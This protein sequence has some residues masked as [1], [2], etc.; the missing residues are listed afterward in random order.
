MTTTEKLNYVESIMIYADIMHAIKNSVELYMCLP[1]PR[2]RRGAAD[3]I[4]L[5]LSALNK[6][7]THRGAHV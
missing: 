3:D 4:A 5:R 2:L 7:V 1:N 6:L